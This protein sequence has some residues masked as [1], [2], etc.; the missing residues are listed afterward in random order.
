MENPPFVP[1]DFS[2]PLTLEGPGFTLRPLSVHDNEGDLEA[3]KS[4]V[5]HIHATPGFEGRPWPDE[6]MTLERNHED[7]AGHVDDFAARRGFTYTVESGGGTIGCVYIYPSETD[8]KDV[9][10][11]SWVRASHAE[12]DEPLYT[13]V[14]QWLNDAWP[15]A[16]VEYAAR[17]TP[18]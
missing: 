3:W 1:D 2:I 18:Q 14:T 12:E 11:R 8:G 10:V 16:A 9:S 17:P 13:A 4:S 5:D 7:L 15:F 6:P